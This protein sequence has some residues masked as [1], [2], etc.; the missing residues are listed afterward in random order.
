MLVNPAEPTPNRHPLLESN[1]LPLPTRDAP[2]TE[3][4]AIA[5]QPSR[6]K[7]SQAEPS[8]R[9]LP[10]ALA[11]ARAQVQVTSRHP[12]HSLE[13]RDSCPLAVLRLGEDQTPRPV[14]HLIIHLLGL[15]RETVHELP[16]GFR[17]GRLDH[18]VGDLVSLKRLETVRLLLLLAHRD[19][20]VGDHDVGV[21][22]RLGRVVGED[23][24]AL[25]AGF[26]TAR[27]ASEQRHGKAAKQALVLKGAGDNG[28]EGSSGD[29]WAGP[30]TLGPRPPGRQCRTPSARQ[31]PASSPIA[32]P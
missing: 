22:E 31:S 11:L 17:P 5:S 15:A 9:S 14:K 19:P 12:P 4:G 29:A 2:S 1:L 8:R 30:L 7:P 16:I 28:R 26:G 18:L 24:G 32:E 25:G 6:A 13:A 20:R 27:R 3:V 23:D 21:L 10:S